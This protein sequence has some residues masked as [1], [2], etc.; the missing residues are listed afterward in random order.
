MGGMDIGG[1]ASAI[2]NLGFPAVMCAI[3]F[4]YMDSNNRRH[5]EEI[6]DMRDARQ[7]EFELYVQEARSVRETLEK[8]EDSITKLCYQIGKGN[9][10]ESIYN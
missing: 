9:N 4:W 1:V 10:N 3:L 2:A 7:H 6:K 5:R 8:L